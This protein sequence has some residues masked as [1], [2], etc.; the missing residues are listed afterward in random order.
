MAAV[1]S[2][3]AP[4]SESFAGVRFDGDEAHA[5]ED[6]IANEVA[7]ALVYNGRPHV[8]MMATPA[9]LEDFVLGFSVSEGI[10]RRAGDVLDTRL[11]VLDDGIEANVAIADERFRDLDLGHRNLTG[12]VGCGLCGAETI[13]QAIRHPRPVERELRLAPDQR[14]ADDCRASECAHTTIIARRDSHPHELA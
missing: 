2:R 12:R 11:R 7:V 14:G 6:L 5:T 13:A 1:P 4:A 8:V 10:A 3:R 9:D